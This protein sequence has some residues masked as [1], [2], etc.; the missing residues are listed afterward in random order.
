MLG[1]L[2]I[3]SSLF[4]SPGLGSASSCSAHSPTV[5]FELFFLLPQVL[6][7][8]AVSGSSTSGSSTG[9]LLQACDVC[10]TICHC[11][12]HGYDMLE[13]WL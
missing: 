8:Q 2:Y 12:Y 11:R 7:L 13:S 9:H 3:F 5:L 1:W 10:L 6:W 4:P